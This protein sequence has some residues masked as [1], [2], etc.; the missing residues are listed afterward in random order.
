MA[1]VSVAG[2]SMDVPRQEGPNAMVTVHDVRACAMSLP[3]TSEHLIWDHVSSGSGRSS[4]PRYPRTRRSWASPSRAMSARR[5]SPPSR[6]GSCWPGP[7]T[8]VQLD[9]RA[10]G[11]GRPGG[12]ARVHHRGLAHGRAQARRRRSSGRDQPAVRMSPR[13]WRALEAAG[14][15]PCRLRCAGLG[16]RLAACQLAWCTWPSTPPTRRPRP[17]SGP[18]PWAGR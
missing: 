18:P 4:M 12:D 13:P 14:P 15:P 3:R 1:G 17:G 5:S 10:H 16:D 8:A 6:T 7:A 9:R 11:H 2:G